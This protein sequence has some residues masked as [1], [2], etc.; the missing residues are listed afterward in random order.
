MVPFVRRG[1]IEGVYGSRIRDVP[2]D[3]GLQK[4]MEK[5]NGWVGE[6]ETPEH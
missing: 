4:V 5:M 6:N 3:E 2:P 1:L